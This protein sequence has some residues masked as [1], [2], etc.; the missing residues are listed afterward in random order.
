L[1]L[2]CVVHQRPP[3]SCSYPWKGRQILWP[4]QFNFVRLFSTISLCFCC[5]G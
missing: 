2:S 3:L 4:C 5:Q 1:A